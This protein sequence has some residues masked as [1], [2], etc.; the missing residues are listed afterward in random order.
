[1][2]IIGVGGS[3]HDFSVCL[4]VDGKITYAIEDERI[5]RIKHSLDMDEAS[6]RQCSALTYCL[7]AGKLRL[8]DV[9]LIVGNDAIDRRYLHPFQRHRNKLQLINHHLAH[10]ASAFYPSPFENSAILVIDGVGS[11][12]DAE[13]GLN[14]SMTFY[15]GI[16]REIH[17]IKKISGR[18]Y[19][20]SPV[21]KAE[22][23]IGLFY[24]ILSWGLGFYQLNQGKTMGLAPYGT[25]KYVDYF[26]RFYAM[27]D[28]GNYQQTEKQYQEMTKFIRHT[29]VP[30]GDGEAKFQ[31]MADIAFAGQYHLEQVI[32]QAARYLYEKTK[33][34]NLCLAGGVA[35]NSVANYKILEQTPFENIFIQP[36]AGDN[37]TAIGS[38]LYGCY[39]IQNMPRIMEGTKFSPYLGVEYTDQHIADILDEY[40]DRVSVVKPD[41]IY[42]ATAKL[43]AEGKIIGWFQGRSEIGPRALGNRSILANPRLKQ[44]K[45]TINA[46]IK[47]REAFRPFA[48]VVLE[49][50]QTQY[51]RMQHPS[52][53]MLLV[54]GIHS[55]K[56]E[57]IPAVTHVDG[58]GRVQTVSRELNPI[59]HH[60][61]SAFHEETGTPILLNTSFN[62]NGEPIIESP[63]DA[64]ECFLKIDL[65]HLIINGYILTKRT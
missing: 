51:F 27:N 30:V 23:S 16:G 53:Y 12:I 48:P 31:E 46:R 13:N 35:L 9:D 65:D 6:I 29:L 42:P 4:M 3:S 40:K 55:E 47:H 44:M 33:S 5:T 50:Y 39:Q 52:Y 36:A 22:N 26:S 14:E 21:V 18:A 24:D 63:R 56:Q 54:P 43:L 19:S 60:L 37:G 25:A 38:A 61:L 1:M 59:L 17:E 49:E 58:T 15:H 41:D 64:M 10:A 34:P 28:E 57:E 32:I 2:N 8:E 7:E 62:D 45:D 11:L 20:K